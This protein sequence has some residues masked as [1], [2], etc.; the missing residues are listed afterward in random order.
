[1]YKDT[2]KIFEDLEINIDPRIKVEKLSVSQMQML[3]IAKAVSYKSKVLILD[4]PTSSL[5]ENEVNHLFRIVRKLKI[6]R[7]F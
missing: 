6:I 7:I 5:T 3:E 1:M 4:E 2:K